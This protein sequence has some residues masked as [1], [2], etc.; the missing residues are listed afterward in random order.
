MKRRL[1]AIFLSLTL[2]LSLVPSAWAENEGD[3]EPYGAEDTSA[4]ESKDGL[5]GPCGATEDD[6]V[7]W[8]LTKNNDSLYCVTKTTG[9]TTS[10][11][12]YEQEPDA[13]E[14][15]SEEVQAYT[16]TI[17]G[18]GAM[19]DYARNTTPWGLALAAKLL[20]EETT[21]NNVS[22]FC[23]PH[24]T[25]VVFT[26]G[27]N[28][29]YIGAHAFRST[30]IRSIVIPDSVKSIGA[31][32]F[33]MCRQLESITAAGSN[34]NREFYVKDDV[35][36]QPYDGGLALRFFPLA[37]WTG[38]YEIKDGVTALGSN[39]MQM[40]EFTSVTIPASV[41]SINSYAFNSSAIESVT[42]KGVP[43][44]GTEFEDNEL[45]PG[46]G[47]FSNCKNLPTINFPQNVTKLPN[48]LFSG[49]VSLKGFTIPDSVT[50]IGNSAFANTGIT[51]IEIPAG[52][53]TIGSGVFSTSAPAEGEAPVRTS[54]AVNF[55]KSSNLTSIGSACF[56]GLSYKATFDAEDTLASKVFSQAGYQISFYGQTLP[57]DENLVYG[58][59]DA[60][61]LMVVGLTEKGEK[62]SSI[63]IP[64]TATAGDDETYPVVGIGDSVFAGTAGDGAHAN[65]TLKSVKL[66]ANIEFIGGRAFRYCTGLTTVDFSEATK[67]E[68]IGNNAFYDAKSVTA[69]DLS[70]CTALTTVEDS[71]FLYGFGKTTTLRLPGSIESWGT[72]VI[73]SAAVKVYVD[74]TSTTFTTLVSVL[75]KK[76]DKFTF[77]GETGVYENLAYETQYKNGEY[78]VTITGFASEATEK[79]EV[80]IPDEIKG[81]K[82]TAVAEK[83]FSDANG[84]YKQ[85]KRVTIGKNV[86]QIGNYAFAS[87]NG[88]TDGTLESVTFDEGVPVSV[89]TRAFQKYK[90]N[91]TTFDAGNRELTL[92]DNVFLGSSALTLINIP[93]VKSL[94]KGVFH[95]YENTAGTLIING[96]A[97]CDPL[98]FKDYT[99]GDGTAAADS[100]KKATIYAVGDA[101]K[102]KSEVEALGSIGSNILC[103]TNGGTLKNPPTNNTALARPVKAGYTFAGWYDNADFSGNAVTTPTAGKTYYAKWTMADSISLT[104]D[105]TSVDYGTPITLTVA[106]TN[107]SWGYVW[108]KDANGDGILDRRTDTSINNNGNVLVLNNVSESGTYWA[109][110]LDDNSTRTSNSVSVTINKADGTASV[111]LE[112]WTYGETAKEPV[113]TSDTNGINNVT[114]QYKV[115]GADDT[116]YSDTLPINACD[117]T[118][119]AT[120][121]A[122]DNYNEVTATADFTITK[123]TY[124]MTGVKFEDASYTYDGS[125]KTLTISGTLPTGVTVAYENNKLTNAGSVTA[126]AKFTI[127]DSDNYCAIDDMTA[128]LTITKAKPTVSISAK[129]DSLRGGGKVTLTVTGVPE[130][131]K[132]I[133]T[134]DN[135]ITVDNVNGTYSAVLPNRT[136][137][138]TFTLNYTGVE[139]GNYSDATDTCTVSV[140][141][142]S[143]GGGSS[144]S[145]R[146]Y[147]V[148]APST[149]NGDV[150][151][152]PK[153]ASKGDRVT[154]TVTPD[155]GYEL[156]KLT[157]KDAS[158]N[159]LKLTDKGN[160]KYT[161]TMPGSKVTVSAEFVE[162]QAA[163]IFA[164]VPTDAY[165]AKAVEWAVKKGITNGKANGL[166]GSNDPC[167]R[168][169][170]VTFLWRAAGSPA[171]KGTAKVPADVLPGSYCYDAVAWALENG[172]TNGLADGTFGVNN[173]CTRGQSVTFL[174]RAIGKLV[175][176]KAEFGDVLTD[177]YYANAVAWAVENGVTNGIGDGLFGPDNSCTR[178]QI[179]TFL[180]RAYQGK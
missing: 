160:G 109:V 159:K 163:S 98:T 7:A 133:V 92:G 2:M 24:I 22:D 5:S 14:G 27:S 147:A 55:K 89:G 65:T 166:F 68:R 156:D 80:V 161:F 59:A 104:A 34:D 136:V 36:Y 145:D 32:A 49:D 56:D 3:A 12:F 137:D 118:V 148:T 6:T 171:P 172:I 38:A 128:T 138:Y 155:K 44:F 52:V 62:A 174:F 131:G 153:N 173:T 18:E 61:S 132:V 94:G 21:D 176:S 47:A 103:L 154:I 99:S 120:F 112:S 40:A 88:R 152:S 33:I 1:L 150:T 149:K 167:T 15:N 9:D 23:S 16:L 84:S 101:N 29:T 42:F 141:R 70:A 17:S 179:V 140:T 110:V 45:S 74:V 58:W 87:S 127:P 8:A 165:Y 177:S 134:C 20:N 168:G 69:W 51:E 25:R 114:Y 78:T 115:K 4:V 86:S 19:A 130:E 113:L 63:A 26:E 81:M 139:N 158:G 119:K 11:R 31:Y 105:K 169:Q 143:S 108:Y 107:S 126:T 95:G 157:V 122:T 73:S 13:E 116:T 178:A 146:S 72:D 106:P 60:S 151:V 170:I 79:E 41:R 48:S 129:P 90:N 144:S 175:D 83:A 35:V 75:D 121:A 53:T 66:G 93:N 67:L 180:Y 71:A 57:E 54:I 123:A 10:W 142:R 46:A 82:V 30:S 164:D 102:V 162:E 77:G 125:E 96:E 43:S 100:L 28:V 124:N 117:Y 50:E 76:S 64:A 91:F 135:G 39:S 85:I 111:R 37:K 97:G